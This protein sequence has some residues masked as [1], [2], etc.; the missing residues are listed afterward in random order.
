MYGTVYGKIA[1]GFASSGDTGVG[2]L[3]LILI[4]ALIVVQLFVVRWLWNNV[5]TRCVSIAK[6]I[7]SLWYTLG[8]LVLIALIHPGYAAVMTA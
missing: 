8:L 7:P 4:V 5:L 2:L 1:E 3:G 6:P